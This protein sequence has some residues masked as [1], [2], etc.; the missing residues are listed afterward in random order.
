[1]MAD[2]DR[3]AEQIGEMAGHFRQ[4]SDRL[5]RIEAAQQR[6]IEIADRIIERLSPETAVKD[7]AFAALGRR[8]FDLERRLTRL[9]EKV[10]YPG[11][12][13]PEPER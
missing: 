8:Y 9:E 12:P 10:H 4:I 3:A 13:E 6:C 1:M 7:E 11:K 2:W 5:D